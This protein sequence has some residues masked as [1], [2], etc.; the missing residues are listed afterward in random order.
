[1]SHSI[2]ETALQE[3]EPKNKVQNEDE[4]KWNSENFPLLTAAVRKKEKNKE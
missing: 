4:K 2:F 1:M 3:F